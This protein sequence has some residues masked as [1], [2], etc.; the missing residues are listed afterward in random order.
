MTTKLSG[1]KLLIAEPFLQDTYFMRSV[2]VVCEHSKQSS[3]GFILNKLLDIKLNEIVYSFPE[4]DAPVFYGGPVQNDNL[5][6]LHSLG[7]LLEGSMQVCPGLY[8]GGD[9]EKL[10]FLVS[11]GL[12]NKNQIRF[13]VGYSGWGYEQ[14][15]DELKE[16][17]W[18][19]EEIDL[20]YIFKIEHH[21]LWKTILQNKGHQF[22][23]IS[24]LPD[25]KTLQN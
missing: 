4:F 5:H 16:G 22:S 17:T 21:K 24:E 11:N 6:Y 23:A 1:G 7:D 12:V 20:N 8:F 9:Y 15:N 13:F 3:F 19:A 18:I 25:H 14:L 10:K 2:L